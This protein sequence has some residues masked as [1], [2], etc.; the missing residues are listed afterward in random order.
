MV[1]TDRIACVIVV[2]T[3]VFTV[4]GT[5][6]LCLI[7]DPVVE[8]TAGRETVELV[9]TVTVIFPCILVDD[10]VDDTVDVN[11]VILFSLLLPDSAVLAIDE[12]STLAATVLFRLFS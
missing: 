12:A 4:I 1:G 5:V 7:P 9:G 2:V 8:R 3:V 11:K 6:L 10:T